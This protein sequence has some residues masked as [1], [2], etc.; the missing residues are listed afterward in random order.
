VKN[1]QLHRI[2]RKG[3]E[4]GGSLVIEEVFAAVDDGGWGMCQLVADAGL[5]GIGR[6]WLSIVCPLFFSCKL[7]HTLTAL[8][9]QS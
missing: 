6:I 8:S 9:R 3:R 7:W 5:G 4:G 2:R 1:N